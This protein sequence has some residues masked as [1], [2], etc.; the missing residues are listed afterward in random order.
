MDKLIDCDPTLIN[1]NPVW[2][3]DCVL[4]GWQSFLLKALKCLVQRVLLHAPRRGKWHVVVESPDYCPGLVVNSQTKVSFEQADHCDYKGELTVLQN[5]VHLSQQSVSDLLG[6]HI[7]MPRLH[8][9]A[10]A[11]IPCIST[12]I[13]LRAG[14]L[15][16]FKKDHSAYNIKAEDYL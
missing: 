13:H 10:I 12:H 8:S 9:A 4:L 7:C 2:K 14:G 16:H 5:R 3:I 11:A 6:T 15:F 1:S